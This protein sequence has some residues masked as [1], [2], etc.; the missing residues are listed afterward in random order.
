M[1]AHTCTPHWMQ[2]GAKNTTSCSSET[3]LQQQV[4]TLFQELQLTREQKN[5]EQRVCISILTLKAQDPP[6]AA[7]TPS[8]ANTMLIG[9][10]ASVI[11]L[12]YMNRVAAAERVRVLQVRETQPTVWNIL[13]GQYFRHFPSSNEPR[14]MMIRLRSS[15]HT[16]QQPQG[17]TFSP[18]CGEWGAHVCIDEGVHPTWQSRCNLHTYASLDGNLH[19]YIRIC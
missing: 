15:L 10:V 5:E 4:T 17:S 19:I 6:S 2:A 12:D 7:E 16:P 9:M 8:I 13:S 18:A 14:P 1:I 11:V 3:K